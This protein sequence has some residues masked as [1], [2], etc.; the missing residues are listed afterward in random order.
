MITNQLLLT[1]AP[2]ISWTSL[3]FVDSY[4]H[5][6]KCDTLISLI[7]PTEQEGFVLTEFYEAGC[8]SPEVPP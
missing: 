1:M 8:P 7:I 5:Q 2:Q 6:Q 3:M 4:A